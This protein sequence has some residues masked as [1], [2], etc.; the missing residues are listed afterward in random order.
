MQ[1]SANEYTH[2]VTDETLMETVPHGNENF[3]FAYYLEDLAQFDLHCADWHWHHE[4][5][6]ITVTEGTVVCLIEENRI[7]LRPDFGLFVNSGVLHRYECTGNKTIIPNIVFSPSL[8][9]AEDSLIY[10]KYVLPIIN[11][12]VSY[13]ILNPDDERQKDILSI[14]DSI[15][16]ISEN[17]S[18]NELQILQLVLK[19]WS[20][21]FN[22]FSTAQRLSASHTANHRQS[23]LRIMLQFIHD[24]Y[25]YPI[26]LEEIA[27][28]ASVCKSSALSIFQAGIH[29]SPVAYL[30][31]YRLK[32]AC[33]LLSTTEKSITVIAAE[34]GFSNAGYFC[35]KFK[36]HYSITPNQYK[37]Q[38]NKFNDAV[39]KNTAYSK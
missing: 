16:Y 10:E 36:E 21:L 11:S 33:K 15:Y 9:A 13:L 5:E 8:I 1:S 23:K 32:R 31:S 17:N 3:P 26:T 30:I 18:E 39:Y 38:K 29:I 19:I 27:S 4:I 37:K 25:K 34:T 14:L 28:S 24:R 35:R 7:E 12:E 2:I 20:I 6:F 22:S